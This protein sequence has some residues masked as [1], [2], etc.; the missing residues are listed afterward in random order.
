MSTKINYLFRCWPK[1]TI[2]TASWLLNQG[3]TRDLLAYYRKSGWVKSAGRGVVIRNGDRAD[4][5]GG[6][7]ALQEQL[8]LPIHPGGKTAL[9]MHG[10]GHYISLG[11]VRVTL[12]S[13]CNTNTPAWF[14]N[15]QWNAKVLIFKTNLFPSGCSRGLN[16]I[17]IGNFSITISS[18]ERAIMEVLYNLPKHESPDETKHLMAGLAAL[19]PKIVQ[20]LLERCASIKVKRLFMILAEIEGHSWLQRIDT[21]RINFGSGKRSLIK[22]GYLHPGYNITVPHTWIEEKY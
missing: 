5:P 8:N 6:I 4:W 2:A 18:P 12:F 15:Y 11:Q 10:Y 22:G 3:I 19:Q 1:D 7:Y 9:T 13:R 16:K 21:S 14:S 17:D 20:E